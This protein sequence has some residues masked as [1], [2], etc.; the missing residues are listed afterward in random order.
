MP[1]DKFYYWKK[2]DSYSLMLLQALQRY[3]S[4][5]IYGMFVAI[6]VV[7]FIVATEA[8]VVVEVVVA[9]GRMM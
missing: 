5:P 6:V 3:V 2:L 7:G 9:A 4:L 1:D 8:V